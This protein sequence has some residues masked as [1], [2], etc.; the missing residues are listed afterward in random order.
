MPRVDEVVG[1]LANRERSIVALGQEG[2][3]DESH[4]E[5]FHLTRLVLRRDGSAPGRQTAGSGRMNPEREPPHCSHGCGSGSWISHIKWPG[6]RWLPIVRSMTQQTSGTDPAKVAWEQAAA[7]VLRKA[8]RLGAEEPDALVWERLT[9]STLD[10][11]PVPALGV[12]AGAEIPGSRRPIGHTTGWDIR[13]R[14]SGGSSAVAELET[15]ATSL[16]LTLDPG[17][18]GGDLDATLDGVLVDLAPVVLDAPGDSVGAASAFCEWLARR[19]LTP[20]D[21]TNLGADPIAGAADV[22]EICRLARS[23]DVLGFVIDATVAH[24]RGA[25]DAHELAY[26]L[27]AGAAYLRLITEAGFSVDDAFGLVEFRYAATDEQFLTIAKLR[28]ARQLWARVGEI[29]EAAPVAQ[30]QHAVT[31][32]PMMTRYDPWVNMLRTTVAAFAAGTGGADSVT[33]LPFDSALG[34]PDD[35]GRRIA[36]NTSSLLIEESHVAKVADPA[37]GSYAVEQLTDELAVAAWAEFQ[38]IEAAGGLLA[39]TTDSSAGLS[40]VSAA[41]GVAIATRKRPITGVSE[42]PNPGEV[43]P[44]REPHAEGKW[45]VVS[46]AGPYER[47]RDQPLGTVFLAT[48]GP[49]ADHTARAGFARNL[50]AAGGI[51][52]ES[53]G[54][55]GAVGDVLRAYGNQ[56]VVMLAGS[57]TAYA[58][59]GPDLIDALRAA[60]AARLMVAGRPRDLKVDDSFALGDD[61]LAFLTRTREALR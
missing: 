40:D 35:F 28:A 4:P 9:K 51:A 46:Y 60:G 54:A 13:V 50:L 53:A 8:R 1:G 20:A 26:S 49:L 10:G 6:E 15:G 12:A 31:S 23:A 3:A 52:F 22:A 61:A 18:T 47:M 29:C 21:G 59:W 43:L 58:E 48:M 37:G 44:V 17:V 24:D 30:R 5:W 42:F 16:W 39:T 56:S 32:R 45:D 25:S 34:V 14:T 55:T 27:A 36:R 7:A 11:L 2:V 41:R 19:G 57:D 38:R 33:V